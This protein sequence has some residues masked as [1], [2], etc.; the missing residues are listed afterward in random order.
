MSA[1]NR[2]H[3][4]F[5][6]P[7][8]PYKVELR[9]RRSWQQAPEA[10]LQISVGRPG[11]DGD[12]L[13]ALCEWAAARFPRVVLVVSDTLQRHNLVFERGL[14]V[15]CANAES[16][17]EGDE[18][19]ERNRLAIALLRN[20]EILRWDDALQEPRTA[21]ALEKLERHYAA[22]SQF[23]VALDATI[24]AFWSRNA[25]KGGIDTSSKHDRFQDNSRAFLFEELAVF[26]WLCQRD[27][28]DV[29]PGS[30]MESIFTALRAEND[31]FFDAFRKDWVQVDYT[32]N[33]AFACYRHQLAA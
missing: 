24:E 18:W 6:A 15:D 3:E 2:T 21:P 19:L 13:F 27:G 9:N 1:S 23:R 17:R 20:P 8:G 26:A 29:Y 5:P 10:R 4:Q 14:D 16:R 22:S 11:V 28:L 32:R 7:T 31:H 33:R 12:K 30:W 25:S